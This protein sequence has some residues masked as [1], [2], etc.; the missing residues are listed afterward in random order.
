[1]PEAMLIFEYYTRLTVRNVG[2]C[3]SASIQQNCKPEEND[4][5]QETFKRKDII[6]KLKGANSLPQHSQSVKIL[7]LG[8]LETVFTS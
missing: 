4:R 2:F 3:S 8:S 7:I 1:M 5:N 6:I